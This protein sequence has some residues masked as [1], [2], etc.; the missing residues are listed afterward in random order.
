M[1]SDA[2]AV[3]TM[4]NAIAPTANNGNATADFVFM[5][6]PVVNE[7]NAA[8]KIQQDQHE[9]HTLHRRQLTGA[10]FH[11]D[12]SRV[13]LHSQNSLSRLAVSLALLFCRH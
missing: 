2:S 1:F 13:T 12:R 11:P 10:R 5:E 6:A 3:N 8:A 4:I 9:N 7:S